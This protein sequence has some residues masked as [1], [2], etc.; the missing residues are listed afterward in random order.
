MKF[1]NLF[2]LIED[3]QE[4]C[5]VFESVETPEQMVSI[6]ERLK[7]QAPQHL[8]ELVNSLRMSTEAVL[9]DSLEPTGTLGEGDGPDAFEGDDDVDLENLTSGTD[10]GKSEIP[11]EVATAGK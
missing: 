3:T 6:L 8:L 11:T 4:I 9:A 5:A 10:E 2:N 1:R 7:K